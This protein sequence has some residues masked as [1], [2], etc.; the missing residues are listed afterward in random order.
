MVIFSVA[1]SAFFV[2]MSLILLGRYR[3]LGKSLDASSRLA[4]NVWDA[5]QLRLRR[6]DERMIDLMARVEVFESRSRRELG[7]QESKLTYLRPVRDLQVEQAPVVARPQVAATRQGEI[8]ATDIEVLRLLLGGTM[9]SRQI[10]QAI[11]KSREHTARLLKNLFE[12]S[13][14]ERDSGKKPFLYRLT[15]AGRRYLGTG[16]A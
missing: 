15:D 11:G 12:R 16:S 7:A 14:V 9:T 4:R 10:N 2:V 3:R 5:L 6:Q 1:I 8:G 13:L